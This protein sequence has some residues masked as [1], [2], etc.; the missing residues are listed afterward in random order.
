MLDVIQRMVGSEPLERPDF[1][2]RIVDG[3]D[4][5]QPAG[6]VIA[7]GRVSIAGRCQ[8]TGSLGCAARNRGR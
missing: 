5:G 3:R 7:D 8:G 6:S 4:S 2:F 1:D